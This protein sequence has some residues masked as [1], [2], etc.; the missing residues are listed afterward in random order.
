[1][2]RHAAEAQQRR[3]QVET[4]HRH[5][6]YTRAAPNLS[7]HQEPHPERPG[8]TGAATAPPHNSFANVTAFNR[9]STYSH[10]GVPSKPWLP[11]SCFMA[12]ASVRSQAMCLME[13]A[14]RSYDSSAGHGE[15]C[16]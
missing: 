11:S 2:D 4:I 7:C 14:K 9:L 15:G 16:N 8:W 13:R 6:V 5:I 1:M 10:K 3:R 12:A